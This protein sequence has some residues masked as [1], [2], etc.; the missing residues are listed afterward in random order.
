MFLCSCYQPQPLPLWLQ[1]CCDN[2]DSGWSCSTPAS[3]LHLLHVCSETRL[4]LRGSDSE[5]AVKM[6]AGVRIHHLAVTEWKPD[7]HQQVRSGVRG[8]SSASPLFRIEKKLAASCPGGAT[9]SCPPAWRQPPLVSRSQSSEIVQPHD[10]F[11]WGDSTDTR[12]G[13]GPWVDNIYAAL[14]SVEAFISPPQNHCF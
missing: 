11:K 7:S 12:P 2:L 14:L 6:R 13:P 3:L 9:S 1:C 5:S 8:N 4:K 10:C